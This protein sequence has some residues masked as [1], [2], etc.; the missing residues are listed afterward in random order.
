MK[1]ATL[2]QPIVRLKLI[3]LLQI[4]FLLL[5][6]SYYKFI[7][8][9]FGYTNGFFLAFNEIKFI[10]GMFIVLIVSF[11][12]P[13]RFKKPSD[14]FI[15]FQFLFPILPM[16]VLYG[17]SDRPREY[18]YFILLSFFIIISIVRY[19][20]LRPIVV[21]NINFY[22][23]KTMTILIT[24][25][26]IVSIL[27]LNEGRYFNLN[28]M[29][30]YDYRLLSQNSLPSLYMYLTPFVSKVILPIGLLITVI[31]KKWLLSLLLILCTTMVYGLTSVKSIFFYPIL[32][33]I[34]YFILQCKRPVIIMLNGY[35]VV[36]VVSVISFI[37]T[38][39]VSFL[40]SMFL[41][42]LMFIP[43]NINFHYYDFISNPANS[44][45]F[46]SESKLT[47]GLHKS[48]YD[49]I[50]SKVIGSEYFGSELANASTGWIGS[51]YM[52]LG[53]PGLLI[54]A[55]ILGFILNFIDSYAERIDKGVLVAIS[56][57]PIRAIMDNSDLFTALLTHGV[58]LLLI[59]ISM[60]K[61]KDSYFKRNH[62]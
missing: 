7:V 38:D 32:V 52:Q 1:I 21:A 35:I 44:F 36:I 19:I 55:V 39:G 30:V 40:G 59:I 24:V 45:L 31:K 37:S 15:H 60:T 51:G 20:K 29:K 33:L 42:R 11:I 6:Y 48:P 46:W 13:T 3:V 58:L 62:R 12:L 26:Y 28:P 16:L 5:F 47:F 50:F 49:L 17:A 34:V 57:I 53:V 27:V 10:E 9:N 8:P 14:I 41:R 4:A 23:L 2:Y 18:V 56:L 25:L 43:G 54:Y 22:Q 61:F